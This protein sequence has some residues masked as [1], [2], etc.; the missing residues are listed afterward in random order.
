MLTFSI[1]LVLGVALVIG[2][3]IWLNRHMKRNHGANSIE[4][5]RETV[6]AVLKP[7]G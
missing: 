1:G 3:G 4:N 7:G 5:M 2:T 6:V